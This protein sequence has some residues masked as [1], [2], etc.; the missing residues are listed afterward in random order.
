M[1][2]LSVRCSVLQCGAVCWFQLERNA[3]VNLKE[4]CVSSSKEC[5]L[6]HERNV[7]VNL[8][9]ERVST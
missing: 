4:M 3:C 5:V 9:D 2:L 1:G 8:K 6:Q 7:C